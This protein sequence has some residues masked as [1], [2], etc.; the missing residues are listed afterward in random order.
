LD[1]EQ[2]T[3][4]KD[5]KTD[6]ETRKEPGSCKKEYRVTPSWKEK[7]EKRNPVMNATN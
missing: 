5:T 7:N 2:K 6:L 3:K 4:E 1:H